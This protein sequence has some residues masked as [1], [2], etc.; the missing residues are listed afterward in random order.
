MSLPCRRGA[1]AL[2]R[3]SSIT[4][5][6][7]DVQ[8]YIGALAARRES[9]LQSRIRAA[10]A[11]NLVLHAATAGVVR[12]LLGLVAPLQIALD[13]GTHHGFSAALMAECAP[14]ATVHTIDRDMQAIAVAREHLLDLGARVVFHHG[15]AADLLQSSPQLLALQGRVDVVLI[16]A[17]K[18][19]YRRYAEMALEYLRPGGL[20]LLD[21]TLWR[22][23]VAAPGASDGDK[24][25]AVL[26]DTNAVNNAR[27][28]LA[29]RSRGHVIAVAVGRGC[30]VCAAASWRRSFGGH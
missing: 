8:H 30:A 25:T 23:K 10:S 20:L 24:R 28:V 6:D 2:R 26:R 16:D 18:G 22:G 14:E 4:A 21:N 9:A 11:S 17:D 7:D 29:H 27:A 1:A 19:G 3:W 15:N 12:I 13:V 5:T